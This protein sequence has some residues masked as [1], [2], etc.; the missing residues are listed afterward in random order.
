MRERVGRDWLLLLCSGGLQLPLLNDLKKK[1]NKNNDI[2]EFERETGGRD[3]SLQYC[4]S[5]TREI[6]QLT[7]K[8]IEFYV[9]I[10]F[11]F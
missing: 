9:E 5:T 7:K 3:S 4:S 1:K 8:K 11:S 2:N 6:I 10:M